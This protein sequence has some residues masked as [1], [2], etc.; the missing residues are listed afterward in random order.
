METITA[1]ELDGRHIGKNVTITYR[2]RK[3]AQNQKGSS[4]K[5]NV[6]SE[7]VTKIVHNRNGEVSI[8]QGSGSGYYAIEPDRYPPQAVVVVHDDS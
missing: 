7:R 3:G 4:V 5:D 8:K 6:V 2:K 1:M